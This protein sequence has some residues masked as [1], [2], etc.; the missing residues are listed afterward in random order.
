[1]FGYR[2]ARGRGLRL[3]GPRYVRRA[4]FRRRRFG[5]AW[6]SRPQPGYRAGRAGRCLA[7]AGCGSAPNAELE[8]I[9][10]AK[11]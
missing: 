10:E 6:R 3:T 7:W 8:R 11:K 1:M 2:L 5:S 4:A 9:I